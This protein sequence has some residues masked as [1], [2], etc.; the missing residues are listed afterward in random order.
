[1]RSA[2]KRIEYRELV[3]FFKDTLM[4]VG[5][6]AH[7]AEVEAEIGAEVDLC[8][9]HSHGV[10]LLPVM[11]EN[12]RN[13]LTNP[14]PRIDVV[15]EYPASVLAETDRGIGRYVSAVG[16]D[17]AIERAEAYGIGAAAIRGVAHWGRGY[18]YAMRAARVGMIG[19]A[20]T[21]AI[22]NFPA[23]GTAVH[24]LG[25]NPMAIGVPAEDDGEPVV[26][27]IAMTQTAIGRVREAAEKGERVPL[28]WG[29]DAQGKPTDDPVAITDSKRFLPMGEHKG[30]GLAFMIELL[31]A[32]LA[33]GLLCYEQGTEGRPSDTAGG[34][35]KLFIAVRPFGNWLT[36]RVASLQNHLKSV[37]RAEDQGEVQWPGEGSYRRR[38][39]YLERG[40][41]IPLMLATDLEALALDLSVPLHWQA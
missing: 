29:L 9:V 10:R 32:G 11:V 14:A 19:L 37:P 16:M 23:W 4:A 38:T 2:S 13:G 17:M 31:T 24:S 21:N 35:T 8:G 30:S 7:V 28:G 33:G 39:E 36:E 5:V 1:M 18:S 41:P 26:L 40:I 20:F 3:R 34:S 12:I 15:V 6:P 22:V 25:N 27:D